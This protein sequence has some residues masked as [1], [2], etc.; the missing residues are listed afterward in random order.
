MNYSEHFSTRN[1]TP[2]TQRARE[3]QVQNSARG[4]VFELTP[5][6]RLERFL[7]LG[8][9]GGT[10]Y[11]SEKRLT[12]ENATTVVKCWQESPMETMQLICAISDQGRAPKNDAAIFALALGA[13][14]KN[15]KARELAL[16]AVKVVCRTG[17]H[18]FS[19]A[20]AV[21]HFRGWGRGLRQ[22]VADWYTSKSEDKLAYQLVK[23]QSRNGWSHKDL[24]R[25]SHPVPHTEGQ[26]D[27]FRW[28]LGK[29]TKAKLPEILEGFERAKRA[30]SVREVVGLIREFGLTHE[31][32]P[33]QFKK[34]ASVWSALLERMPLGAM[35]RNLGNMS[36]VGLIADGNWE[37]VNT[38]ADRL[39]NEEN[40]R[41]ARV[42]PLAVLVAHHVYSQGHGVRGSGTWDV[43]GRVVDALDD[44]FYKAFGNVRPS[45]QRIFV[46]LDVSG[47]MGWEHVAG[48][49]GLTARNAAAAMSMLHLRT[50]KNVMLRAFTT[51]LLDPGIRAKDS[52]SEVIRKTSNLRFGGTDCSLPM[53]TAMQEKIAVDA[54]VVYTDNETWAGRIQPFE[55]LRQYRNR[56]GINARLV[57]VGMTATGFTIADPRDPG[58]LDVVGFDTAAPDLM[59]AFMRGEI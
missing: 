39:T 32:I 3:D 22:T 25:L 26:N 57:V 30:T 43:V 14:S 11:A 1:V 44:A 36:K 50:E 49:S 2:Q 54:F 17:T 46:A 52:L 23:Y 18:L 13:A 19:F 10:Y 4:F 42:H 9:E 35:L 55:A 40:L 51:G 38:V 59:S 16:D 7:I 24:L 47:S 21:K 58:M 15:E 48:L 29:E 27:L 28:T 12:L 56:M 53:L 8:N 6:K 5:M 45:G 37:T 34:E 31:M 33:T 20:E 41:K